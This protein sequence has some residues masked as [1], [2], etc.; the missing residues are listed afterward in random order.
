[1]SSNAQ[2]AA[3][4]PVT[5]PYASSDSAVWLRRMKGDARE[6][7]RSVDPGPE[8]HDAP[9]GGNGQD[10]GQPTTPRMPPADQCAGFRT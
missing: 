9:K 6:V 4:A 1:M 3:A 8:R 2:A 10:D 5:G 7:G